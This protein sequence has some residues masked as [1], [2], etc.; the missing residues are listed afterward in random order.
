MT[1]HR[2]L[3]DPELNFPRPVYIGRY[4]YWRVEQLEAWEEEQARKPNGRYSIAAGKGP[5]VA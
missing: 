3:N 5:G 4:R 1:I 2:W